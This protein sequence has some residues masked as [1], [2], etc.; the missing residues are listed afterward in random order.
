[1]KN[2]GLWPEELDYVGFQSFVD[3]QID[4]NVDVCTDGLFAPWL[5]HKDDHLGHDDIFLSVYE[6][7][8]LFRRFKLAGYATIQSW[9]SYV[10]HLTCRG[11]QFEH[12]KENAD[13]TMKSPEWQRNN[14]LSL[15]EYI[16]KW[17]GMFKED[18]PC[19]PK[20]NKKYDI[21]LEVSNCNSDILNF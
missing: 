20:P 17:G 1:V 4:N 14:Y 15:L 16:R 12:A 19:V 21:G 13:F 11:G 10:Y 8:D 18:G 7:A 9:S 2:F 3:T 5:I 6:D